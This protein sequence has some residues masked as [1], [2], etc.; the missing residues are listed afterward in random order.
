MS[1]IDG[2]TRSHDEH[3]AIAMMERLEP[4]FSNA[5]SELTERKAFSKS[6]IAVLLAERDAKIEV[7]RIVVEA[8]RE[9]EDAAYGALCESNGIYDNEWRTADG[10]ATPEFPVPSWVRAMKVFEKK[11]SILRKSL[12]DLDASKKKSDG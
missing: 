9:V 10:K 11:W 8:A 3:G 12:K 2:D 7:L 5:M 1:V 4:H 6:E